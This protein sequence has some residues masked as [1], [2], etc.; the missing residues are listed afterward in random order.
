MRT[1]RYTIPLIE[2]DTWSH[3]QV[4]T[5]RKA[6][7]RFVRLCKSLAADGFE[8]SVELKRGGGRCGLNVAAVVTGTA[9]AAIKRKAV[10]RAAIAIPAKVS[11]VK[12]A[13]GLAESKA[14]ALYGSIVVPRHRMP[15]WC[16]NGHQRLEDRRV[17]R[18][19][20]RA[21]ARGESTY[22]DDYCAAWSVSATIAE[23]LRARNAY[24]GTAPDPR[25]IREARLIA[26][27]EYKYWREMELLTGQRDKTRPGADLESADDEL[28]A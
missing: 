24:M 10:K 9:G 2:M 8:Y 26:L 1:A 19:I 20:A 23:K 18:L 14:R 13:K 16:Y 6:F 27:A 22:S 7:S 25:E 21:K 15:S 28:A 12:V 5:E 17:G 11:P 3:N 4:Q